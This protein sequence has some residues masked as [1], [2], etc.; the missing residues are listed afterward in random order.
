M[1]L[2]YIEKVDEDEMANMHVP[3]TDAPTINI[4]H[5]SNG[6]LSTVIDIDRSTSKSRPVGMRLHNSAKDLLERA[7]AGAWQL[8][9]QFSL[10]LCIHETHSALNTM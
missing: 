2:L 8:R 10:F 4:I 1:E 3:D 7:I 6:S 9:V 5:S